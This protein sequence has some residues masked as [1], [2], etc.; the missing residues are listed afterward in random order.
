MKIK[1]VVSALEKLGL[2]VEKTVHRN[3]GDDSFTYSYC[4]KSKENRAEWYEQP[5]DNGEIDSVYI[6]GINQRDDL[7]SD[8]FPGSFYHTIKSIVKRMSN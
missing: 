4:F 3:F 7:M 6:C 5:H 8:Y 1:N 2:T